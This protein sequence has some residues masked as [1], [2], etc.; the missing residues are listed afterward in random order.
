MHP[1]IVAREKVIAA[2]LRV[3]S[4]RQSRDCSEPGPYDDAQAEYE[5]DALDQAL[6]AYVELANQPV[7]GTLVLDLDTVDTAIR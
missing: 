6:K 3:A 5:M 2:A 4:G 1:G 7:T